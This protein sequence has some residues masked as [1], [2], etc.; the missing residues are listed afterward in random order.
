MKRVIAFSVSVLLC[1]LAGPALSHTVKPGEMMVIAEA[2]SGKAAPKPESAPKE[3]T[4]KAKT[5]HHATKRHHTTHHH[6][7]KQPA[8]APAPAQ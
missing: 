6:A 3:G 2:E 1:G 8:P 4:E 7:K 5:T